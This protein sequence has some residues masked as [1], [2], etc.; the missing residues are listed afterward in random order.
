MEVA[1]NAERIQQLGEQLYGRVATFVEHLT[2]MGRNLASTVDTYNK[3]V[4]SLERQVLP[5]ARKFQELGLQSKKEIPT[6]QSLE[7]VP[8]NTD[9]LSMDAAGNIDREKDGTDN[10]GA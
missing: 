1:E 4:G 8:R 10:D 5:G 7:S 2:K 6:A 3:A 9:H